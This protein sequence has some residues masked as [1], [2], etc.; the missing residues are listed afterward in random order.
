[1]ENSFKLTNLHIVDPVSG[2]V[3]A[4]SLC[5][6]G[7]RF[8]ENAENG[9]DCGGLYAAP[10]LVDM[11]VHLREP[12]Q[13]QKEDIASGC[14]A[15]AAGGVTS[16][17]CM[18]NTVPPT[19]TPERVRFILEKARGASA[20]VYPI[21]CV[22]AGMEGA[23][24]TDFA[25]LRAAGAVAFSDDGRPVGNAALMLEA[26]ESGEFVIAHSEDASLT[27]GRA[28]NAGRIA[29]IL[30]VP[31]RPAAAEEYMVA[32]DAM[33]AMTAGARVHI[34]HVST[35][36]SVEIIRRAKAAGARITCE[37][38]PHYFTFTEND[39]PRLGTDGKMYPPLRTERD[40]LAIIEG[41]RDGT[42]DAIATDHAPHTA[43]EKALGIADAPGGVVGLETS[44]AASLTALGG[45]LTLPELFRLLSLNPARLLGIEAGTLEIGAPADLVL[46]DPEETF[47]CDPAVFRS[48]GRSTPFAGMTLRGAV[49]ATYLGG[50]PVFGEKTD[51]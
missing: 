32:R 27:D 19:D 14:A 24:L 20:R 33:L 41:L 9:I 35:A 47:V 39:V 34:A 6:S 26:L 10:G 3:R 13:T 17:A 43:E 51:R 38:A 5:V 1:M 36:G 42:I 4:G 45:V 44:L 11:H 16:V 30:G 50:V 21:A 29:E 25:A 22:T 37:T 2:T 48:K 28:V 12:G 15:A 46:F 7:G 40:R 31:G 23:R 18:A 8:A 49:K